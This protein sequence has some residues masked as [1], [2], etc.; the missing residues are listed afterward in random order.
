MSPRRPTPDDDRL[1]QE[2]TQAIAALLAES[3]PERTQILGPAFA[4]S[5]ASGDPIVLRYD[6]VAGAGRKPDNLPGL[7]LVHE[8]FATELGGEF[9]RTVGSEGHF[10]P[11]RAA[12]VKFAEI[13]ARLPSPIAVAITSFAGIGGQMVITMEPELM[14]HFL[15]LLMGGEG[16]HVTLRGDLAA[17][18]FTPAERSLIAHVTAILSRALA[19]AWSDVTPVHLDLVRVA[20]DPRHASIFEPSE[21]MVDLGLRV[22]WG[23]VRGSIHFYFPQAFLGPFEEVLAQ[24]AGSAR[25]RAEPVAQDAMRQNLE[26]VVVGLASILGTTELTLSRL[27]ALQ[28]GDVLRLDADPDEP[29]TIVV[30]DVPKL[31]GFPTVQHGNVAINVAGWIGDEGSPD[32][33]QENPHA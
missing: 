9:R 21:A 13:Y 10:L 8:R 23:P 32:R 16:G 22:E 7:Q 31:V 33:R 5:P 11:E 18:G 20:T 30:E 24:P 6:L 29:V 12:F 19:T 2:E 28:V 26:P 4:G 17:R 15:D 14:L 25:P 1:T 27:L 3:V